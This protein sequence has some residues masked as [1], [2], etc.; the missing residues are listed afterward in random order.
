MSFD[1]KE[2]LKVALVALVVGGTAGYIA[3]RQAA[4]KA[5]EPSKGNGKDSNSDADGKD[6]K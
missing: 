1:M 2:F 4:T 3:G 6:G 5:L